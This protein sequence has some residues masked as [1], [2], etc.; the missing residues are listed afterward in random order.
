MKR[1]L[2]IFTIILCAAGLQSIIPTK[3]IAAPIINSKSAEKEV[4]LESGDALALSPWELLGE[5]DGLGDMAGSLTTLQSDLVDYASRFIGTR[6]RHGAK[7]PSAFDCSGFT[8]YVFRNFGMTLSPSSRAQGLQ[9][10]QISK[11]EVMVGDLMF[12][13]GR[14]GGKTIGHVG[15]V[16]DVDEATGKVKFIHAATS[17]GVVI[18]SFPDGGYYSSRFLQYR[19]VIGSNSPA[20]ELASEVDNEIDDLL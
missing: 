11:D 3:L 19:R 1:L 10:R 13:S 7:G 14:R 5:D 15:M 4:I 8:S 18:E 6:Y 20:P 9:G 12:F 17:R 16:V 2:Y